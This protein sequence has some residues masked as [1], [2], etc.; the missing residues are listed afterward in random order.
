[1]RNRLLLFLMLV[2][3]HANGSALA[4]TPVVYDAVGFDDYNDPFVKVRKDGK[5]YFC[6]PVTGLLVDEVKDHA[7]NL[8]TVVK[9]GGY[10]VA[11]EN[12]KLLCSLDNDEV[13]LLTDYT[14]QW[15]SGI[16]YNYQFAQ[17]KRKGKY[18]LIDQHGKVIAEPRFQALEVM[19]KDI[20]G[21]KEDDK[22]GWLRVTDGKIIQPPLYDELG[23]GYL[24]D[25]TL[26][27]FL[28]K[29]QGIAHESGQVLIAPEH[30]QLSNIILKTKK[31]VQFFKGK[32][33]G[34]M[35]S[36]G[37][38]VLPAVYPSLGPCGGSDFLRIEEAER[39]GLIDVNGNEVTPAL[40]DKINDFVR[41]RAIVEKAGRK[42]V[43]NERGELQ[44]SPQYEQIELLNSAGQP[45]FESPVVSDVPSPGN[46][47]KEYLNRKVAEDKMKSLPY[48]LRV[49]NHEHKF[50]VYDWA[51]AKVIVPEKFTEI[52]TVYQHGETYFQAANGGIYALYDKK[53]NEIL[54]MKYE[55]QPGVYINQG[56]SYGE[57][58]TS[59][60]ILPVYDGKKLG[61]YDI[62]KKKFLVPPGEV[63]VSWL[64][65]R[66]FEVRRDVPGVSYTKESALYNIDGEVMIP[67]NSDIYQLNVLNDKLLLAEMKTKYVVFDRKGNKVFEHPGWTRDGYYRRYST[68]KFVDERKNPFQSGLFKIRVKEEDLFINESGKEVRFTGFTYVGDF[69]NNLAW[70]IREKEGKAL[71]GLID[72]KGNVVLEPQYDGVESLGDPSTLVLVKKNNKFG[73]INAQGKVILE[74]V[75][76]LISTFSTEFLEVRINDK[77]GLADE[78][79]KIIIEPK[80]DTL[81]RSYGSGK[82][83]WPI[84]A[85][86]GSEFS[87]INGSGSPVLVRGKSKI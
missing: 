62:Q 72:V 58:N 80:F 57:R 30:E 17:I 74:P 41:G 35:D 2:F 51:S 6:H 42:G 16:P 67:Y 8:L 26:Q 47:S 61:I 25:H 63:E 13:K 14:G 79:G 37:I 29:K 54:P 75:Y 83:T 70:V 87:F 7:G 40:Y 81:I 4:Q 24:L 20:I 9:D 21:F 45:A 52:N 76:D 49:R 68:P 84:L 12:G 53:G 77:S 59:P 48:Y 86:E 50:G 22:W 11:N 27:I 78:N 34:L 69:Y 5:N 73:V 23:K 39:H 55:Q 38:I 19:N 28:N 66:C 60:Y 3:I 36:L 71:Y 1:M 18:G 85:Q 32:N 31:Y 15:Y 56:Y 65:E 46:L 33:S 44:L 43:I 64:D 10:G 82:N